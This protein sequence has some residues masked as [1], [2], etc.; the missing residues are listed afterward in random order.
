MIGF[1]EILCISSVRLDCEQLSLV[2]RNQLNFAEDLSLLQHTIVCGYSSASL[3]LLPL[4]R[5]SPFAVSSTMRSESPTLISEIDHV[6]NPAPCNSDLHSSWL[7][8]VE[9]THLSNYCILRLPPSKLRLDRTSTRWYI[10]MYITC[11]SIIK[12]IQF[13]QKLP[14]NPTIVGIL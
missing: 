4:F 12:I 6:S 1:T 2:E 13:I 7:M 8:V 3:R 14:C 9:C 11:L 5:I 10:S